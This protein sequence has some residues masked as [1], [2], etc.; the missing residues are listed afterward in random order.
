M[1]LRSVVWSL[2]IEISTTM[3]SVLCVITLLRD[4]HDF[5]ISR[6]VILDRDLY[7]CEISRVCDHFGLRFLPF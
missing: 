7:D 5:E 2:W 6:V 4:S 1:I 3:K